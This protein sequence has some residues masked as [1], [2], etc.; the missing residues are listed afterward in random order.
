MLYCLEEGIYVK[1][2]KNIHVLNF[3]CTNIMLAIGRG[4]SPGPCN[5]QTRTWENQDQD[6]VQVGRNSSLILFYSP[7]HTHKTYQATDECFEL[8]CFRLDLRFY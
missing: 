7:S 3:L 2:F 5:W 4:L 6:L 1:I 8:T